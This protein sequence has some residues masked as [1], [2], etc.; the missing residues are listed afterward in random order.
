MAQATIYL[1]LP[2]LL[3]TIEAD[4]EAQSIADYVS[5]YDSLV[6]ALH[7]KKNITVTVSDCA[8][9]AWL[10]RL[11]E[12]ERY[13]PKLI[14]IEE[15]TLRSR[16]SQLWQIDIPDWVSDP[17]IAQADLLKVKIAAQPDRDFEDFVLETFFS[18]FLAQPQIPLQRLNSFLK[19][20]DPEQ[21]AAATGRPLVGD[22]FRR[23]LSQ[24][25][26]R[27]E[28]AGERLIIQWLQQSPDVLNEQLA[29]FRV[30]ANYPA[31]VGQR[32]IGPA[33]DALKKLDLDLSNVVVT[34][35]SL[36]LILDQIRVHLEQTIRSSQDKNQTLTDILGQV[37]GCLEMEFEAILRLLRSGQVAI[38]QDLVRQIRGLFAPIQ[39]RPHLDQALTDLDLLISRPAPPPPNPDPTQPW[40]DEQ[41]LDWAEKHYLPY[42]F[43]LEEIG[44]LS[45][46]IVDYANAYADWLYHRYPAM[47]LES[48]RL[49]YQALPTLKST[50]MEDA[51]VLILVIDNFNAKFCRDFTR[52]MQLQG[53]YSQSLS[54]YLAML[55]SCTEISKKCLLTGQPE[56]F[57]GTAYERPVRETWQRQLP[58]KRVC[59]LP[60]VGA[61]RTIKQRQHDIYF[62]NYLP[63]DMTFHQDETHTGISH[64]QAARSYLRAIARDVRAFG[65]RIGAARDL[66]VIVVSD[67]GS[68]RI[69]AQAPNLIDPDFFAKRVTDK[70]HRYVSITDNELAELPD[71]T[72]YQCYTFERRRFDL[73]T[74]YLAAKGY[75]RFL[76]TTENT[77]IHGGLTPEETM[78]PVAIFTPQTVSAK[79]L[80]VHLL[81]STF[82]Y[83]RK[84]DIKLELINA[85]TYPCQEV[86]IEILNPNVDTLAIELNELGAM[87]ETKVLL[88]GRFRRSRG[89]IESLQ[90]RTTYKF[91]EQPQQQE[92]Q[93]PVELKSMM[94][95]A[96]DLNELL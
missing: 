3:K 52:Y 53:Y 23:R 71:N 43:W 82:Y 17:Q 89:K 33:F 87:S 74:N 57:S 35:T 50:M 12:P 83:E 38:D 5:V 66:R 93:Q 14:L 10:K 47:R 56:P 7:A 68:T 70:H 48:R 67:H 61:L 8:V 6:Q 26:A 72:K 59:Y 41:W 42:R 69:P 13:G 18:P 86:R 76:S 11:Q 16:L 19:S 45:G 60:H 1:G 65:E 9:G 44:E 22:I 15:L 75:Y 55:P 37:S 73:P 24:W 28:A 31:A 95:Q 64:A 29:S 62:L 21:W 46:D 2:E 39:H 36:G 32:A 96:F 4:L 84:S 51:P 25:E 85:N 78:V 88:E 63:L 40:T 81:E 54:Y 90:I 79:P 49:L 77:Y 34:E 91:L 20:Y 92:D 27:A 80:V 58:N 94:T 30:L